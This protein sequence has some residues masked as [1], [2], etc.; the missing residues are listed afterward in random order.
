MQIHSHAVVE[1]GV[2]DL[3]IEIADEQGALVKLDQNHVPRRRALV[4]VLTLKRATAPEPAPPGH[5][6]PDKLFS[7]AYFTSLGNWPLQGA[8]RLAHRD[9]KLASS[10]MLPE[11]N[12]DL[13]Q[14]AIW[15]T[16][17]HT[18]SLAKIVT[19]ASVVVARQ[20]IERRAS[21]T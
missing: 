19:A 2:V 8:A 21:V 17:G 20:Y 11:R 14:G 3:L 18:E 1:I 13:A 5:P 15:P 12:V 10:A 7:P 16:V 9:P 6:C 4:V